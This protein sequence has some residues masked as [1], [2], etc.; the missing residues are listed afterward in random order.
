MP[1]PHPYFNLRLHRKLLVAD[2]EIGFVGGL[3]VRDDCLLA[4]GRKNATQDV[5]FRLRGPVVKQLLSAFAF[6]WEFTTHEALDGPAWWPRL[7]QAGTMLARGIPDGPDEDFEAIRMTMLGAISQATRLVRVVTPYFLPDAS[8]IDALRVAAL[9][10]VRVEI[11]LPQ[12]GNLRAVD[13][14]ARAQLPQLLAW[15]CHVYLSPP[16]F[17]HSKLFVVD[18]A[19]SL[20][21]SANWDPRSLRL[22]F[23]YGVECYSA[24]LAAL[25][26]ALIDSKIAKSREISLAELLNRP[27]V[28]RLRDGLTWL[29]QPY[30]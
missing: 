23:E 25:L 12:R 22:N 2:G 4:L 14:A 28:L 8:L 20:V 29:A 7:Q 26:D 11:V 10:G 18:G 24:E 15:G 19:W 27:L 9:R 5:H 16:P 6:D 1:L 13:W 3:N 30:L 21:G 17:D